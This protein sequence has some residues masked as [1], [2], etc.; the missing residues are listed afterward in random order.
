M[1]TTRRELPSGTATFT[2]RNKKLE[3][4]VLSG[5]EGPNV[6]DIRKLYGDDAA[7]RLTI[8]YGGSAKP[9]NAVPLLSQRDVDGALVGGA[10]LKADLF[11]AIVRIAGG[12]PMAR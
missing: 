12:K 11:L 6:V 10:S 7:E 8:Q 3:L 2:Y 9:E 1:S 4:P 5:T